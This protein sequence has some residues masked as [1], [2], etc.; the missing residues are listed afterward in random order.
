M[1]RQTLTP[2]VPVGPYPTLQPAVNTLDLTFTVAIVADKEQF[3]ASG[4]DLVLVWNK[5]V[6]AKTVTFTSVADP[7]TKRTGDITTYSIG[8]GEIAGFRFS[9]KAGWMQSDGKIYMEAESTD[10]YY[11]VIALG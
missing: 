11:C 1:A 9:Q 7:I 8:A 2:V 6:A 10:I 4:N 5:A 3:A